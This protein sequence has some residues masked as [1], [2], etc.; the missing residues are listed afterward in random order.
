[1]EY[2]FNMLNLLNS[3][4]LQSISTGR[5]LIDFTRDAIPANEKINLSF[6]IELALNDDVEN[7]KCLLKLGCKSQVDEIPE[8]EL[9]PLNLEI[10]LNYKFNVLEPE[11][12]FQSNDEIRAQLLSSI[13]YLDFRT[14]LTSAFTSVGLSKL[15]FPLSLEK[16]KSMGE[17]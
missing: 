10:V 5:Q 14:K 9:S 17:I 1:M 16:L 8:G 7:S 3:V 11:I 15:R 12:F 6:T 13:V 2:S 4:E